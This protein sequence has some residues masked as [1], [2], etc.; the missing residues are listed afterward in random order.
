MHLLDIVLLV[1]LLWAVYRGFKKGLVIEI[2]SLVSLFL[3]VYGAI[4]LSDRTA[5]YLTDQLN[6]SEQNM[7]IL[8]FAITFIVIVGVVYLIGRMIEKMIDLVALSFVNKAGGAFFSGLKVAMIISIILVTLNGWNDKYN[9]LPET[10]KEDSIAFEPLTKLSPTVMP[11][12]KN[13]EWVQ[14]GLDKLKEL[15]DETGIL[16]AVENEE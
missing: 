9:F 11:F 6:M 2:T 3:G 15:S 4:K 8:S 1:P 7:N 12:L 14:K 5:A 16:D 13:S 10:I